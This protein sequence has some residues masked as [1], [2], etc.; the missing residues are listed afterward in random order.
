MFG[1][2]SPEDRNIVDRFLQREQP[3]ISEMTFANMYVWRRSEP[4]EVSSL[5]NSLIFKGRCKKDKVIYSPPVGSDNKVSIIRTLAKQC[6]KEGGALP[7]KG[8]SQTP[9]LQTDQ[10]GLQSC[11]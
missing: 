5:G 11:S 6:S 9:D 2:L 7:Y 10:G 3:V 1:A 4:V 8:H